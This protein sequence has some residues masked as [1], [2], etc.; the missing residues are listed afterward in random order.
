MKHHTVL[1]TQKHQ[2]VWSI[3][4]QLQCCILDRLTWLPSLSSI[5][6]REYSE[7]VISLTFGT[8]WTEAEILLSSEILIDNAV[9]L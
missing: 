9:L 2:I 1:D 8:L 4:I 5:F 7:G 3:Q 6:F